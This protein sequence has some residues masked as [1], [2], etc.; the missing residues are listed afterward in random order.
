MHR[1]V[2]HDRV[3]ILRLKTLDRALPTMRRAIIHH[4]KHPIGVTIGCL[5]H[6]LI[7]QA[8][9]RDNP[10]FGFTAAHHQAAQNIP[11]RQILHGATAL[12]FRFDAQGLAWCRRHAGVAADAGLDTCFFVATDDKIIV[13]KRLALPGSTPLNR[14]EVQL[15]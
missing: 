6:H 8:A 4:P 11:G 1:R 7:D 14:G 2:N 5:L 13:P 15:Q 3:G 10:R 12:I 9:K